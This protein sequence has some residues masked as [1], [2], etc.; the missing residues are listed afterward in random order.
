MNH[1]HERMSPAFE[2]LH[3]GNDRALHHFTQ[4]E[5]HADPHSH[6][7]DFTTTI[8]TGG[9]VEEVFTITA[10]GWTSERIHRRPGATHRIEAGHIHRIVELPEAECFTFV[11]AGPHVRKVRF[12]RF[13]AEVLVRDWD[14]DEWVNETRERVS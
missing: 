4:A 14:R 11:Q 12:Y 3:L 9:Y 5:P 8:L 6:P 13:G 7:W 1:L 10:D 2:K